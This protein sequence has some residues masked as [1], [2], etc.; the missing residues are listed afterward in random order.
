MRV[1]DERLAPGVEDGEEA[2]LGAEVAGVGGDGAQRL[3]HGP[4]EE[5]VD[6][7][8]VLDGDLGD[9]RRHGEDD[10]EVLGGQQVRPAPLEPRGAGQGLTARTVA[11]AA[12][13]VPDAPM[14]AVA[15]LLDVAAEGGGA[16]LLDGRHHAA[17]RRREGGPDLGSEVVAVAAEDL[18]YGERGAWHGRSS[19]DGLGALWY[20]PREVQRT[21]GRADR[22]GGD[23]QIPRRRLQTPM[24]EQKLNRA[25]VGAGLEEMNSKR[26]TECVWGNPLGK[27]R[28][29][30]GDLASV[31]DGVGSDR[32]PRAVAREEPVPGPV[33]LPPL[34]ED[35]QQ[36]RREHHVAVLPALAVRDAQNHAAAVDGGHGEADGL[37]DA[38]AGGV[39]RGQDGVMLGGLHRI[40]ELQHLFPAQHDG[41]GPRLL[42]Q[43]D[44]VV[45]GPPL[46]ERDPIE[47]A[48]RRNGDDQRTRSETAFVGQVDLV[49]A[50]LLRT[51]TDRG[52]AEVPGEPRDG[53][54]VDLLGGRRQ[55]PHLHVF[56]HALTERCHG[57]LL[58]EGPGGFQARAE[59]RTARDP[60]SDDLAGRLSRGGSI[61]RLPRSGLLRNSGGCPGRRIPPRR[62]VEEQ[63]G[64]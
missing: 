27:V 35:R 23:L 61:Q 6:D 47:E 5:T 17:L 31:A 13:V 59:Q 1:M 42:R 33:H 63:E 11:V 9:R 57:T 14:A 56:E 36:L 30:G 7:G 28:A 8:L 20:G 58:C 26:V 60:W 39:A 50:D 18:G 19:V 22:A 49:G 55:L 41:Q 10:V 24:P 3:G 48:Q 32:R 21:L 45:E 44:E 43:G 53:P 15:T 29:S 37:G 62:K 12:G 25:Q 4:E 52:P 54:D 46:L 64:R 16:T 34:A 38:Q 2:D 40:E 51:Q